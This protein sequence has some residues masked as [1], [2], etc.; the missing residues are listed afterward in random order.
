MSASFEK[1]V[2]E[3][4]ICHIIIYRFYL[5]LDMKINVLLLMIHALVDQCSL[6][7]HTFTICSDADGDNVCLDVQPSFQNIAY[8]ERKRDVRKIN[9]ILG[10]TSLSPQQHVYNKY[11]VERKW[12]YALPGE[13]L[14]RLTCLPN[15]F[16]PKPKGGYKPGQCVFIL[17][18]CVSLSQK[19]EGAFCLSLLQTS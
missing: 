6:A 14:V 17:P 1:G 3:F 10:N 8:L 7:P 11:S 16:G 15:T 13:E 12:C 9:T 2:D 18:L 19:K 4:H 5:I